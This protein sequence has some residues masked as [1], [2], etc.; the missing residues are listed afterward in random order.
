MEPFGYQMNGRDL[1]WTLAG[2]ESGTY[3]IPLW[4]STRHWMVISHVCYMR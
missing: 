4:P 2:L 1:R 3:G